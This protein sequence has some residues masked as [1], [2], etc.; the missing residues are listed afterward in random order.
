MF[1]VK[2]V[3]SNGT[4]DEGARAPEG[5]QL[6]KLTSDSLRVN[7]IDKLQ[8][9]RT[10]FV[11]SCEPQIAVFFQRTVHMNRRQWLRLLAI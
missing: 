4:N 11:V 2:V 5:L 8:Y 3:L 7:L 10:L 9:F 6:N 1:I